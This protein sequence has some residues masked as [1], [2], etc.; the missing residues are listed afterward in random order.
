MRVAKEKE[1][2]YD[3]VISLLHRLDTESKIDFTK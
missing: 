2:L 1:V 3:P